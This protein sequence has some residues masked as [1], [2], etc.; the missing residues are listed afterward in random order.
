MDTAKLKVAIEVWR[1][2]EECTL[3]EFASVSELAYFITS[4]HYLFSASE[5]DS[6]MEDIRKLTPY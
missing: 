5:F 3:P 2:S 6:L 4:A 1:D